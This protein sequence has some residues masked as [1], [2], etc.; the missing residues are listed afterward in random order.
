VCPRAFLREPGIAAAREQFGALQT[1]APSLGV[2]VTL[3]NVRTPGALAR[4]SR[5]RT[6]GWPWVAQTRVAYAAKAS[7]YTEAAAVV[8]CGRG[9]RSGSTS[10]LVT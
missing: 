9:A 5:S 6:S 10:R 2:E 8:G 4:V 3:L 1:A 7:L